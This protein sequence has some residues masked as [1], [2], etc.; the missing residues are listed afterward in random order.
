MFG[1]CR[2]DKSHSFSF[3]KIFAISMTAACEPN[4]LW[5]FVS[6]L[7]IVLLLPVIFEFHNLQPHPSQSGKPDEIKLV[8]VYLPLHRHSCHPI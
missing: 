8:V 7:F 3:Q 6:V 5:D 2:D 1:I 4:Y